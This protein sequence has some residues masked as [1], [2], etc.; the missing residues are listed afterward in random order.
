DLT[1]IDAIAGGS[2]NAF[3]FR[4]TGGFTGNGQVRVAGSGA[5][6]VIQVNTDA[7]TAPLRWR[8]SSRMA[9]PFPANGSSATSFSSTAGPAAGFVD[10]ARLRP[11]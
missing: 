10:G 4:G 6:T 9:Q 7:N 5:D 8:S 3:A 1:T 11:P 2:D